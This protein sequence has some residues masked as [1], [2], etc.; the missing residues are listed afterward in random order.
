[1]IRGYLAAWVLARTEGGKKSGIVD[2]YPNLAGYVARGEARPAFTCA[3][4]A[5]LA[6]FTQSTTV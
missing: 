3:F 2:E 4:A 6:A 5:Q 1:M